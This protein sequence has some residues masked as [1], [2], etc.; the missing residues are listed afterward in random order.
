MC[1]LVHL[2]HHTHASCCTTCLT[3]CSNAFSIVIQTA[4]F[5]CCEKVTLFH[6]WAHVLVIWLTRLM[7]VICAVQ[8][9]KILS[10]NLYPPGQNAT[11]TAQNKTGIKCKGVMLNSENTSLVTQQSLQRLVDSFAKHQSV[12]ECITTETHTILRDKKKLQLKNS[13]VLK[14]LQLCTRN[15]ASFRITQHSQHNQPCCYYWRFDACNNLEVQNVFTKY[16]YHRNLSC[17]YCT[18]CVNAGKI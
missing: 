13:T 2:P 7:T 1:L 8:R 3:G 10:Q 9:L 4:L 16:V 14:W 6:R 18:K 11:P 5:L 12:S 17:I 15:G